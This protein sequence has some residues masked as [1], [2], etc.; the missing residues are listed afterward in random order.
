MIKKRS[1]KAEALFQIILLIVGIMAISYTIGSSVDVVSAFEEE[2]VSKEGTPCIF[3]EKTCEGTV[4]M[5]CP[6][7]KWEIFKNCFSISNPQ[8]CSA[9]NCI[10]SIIY[11]NTGPSNFNVPV[12][13]NLQTD[14]GGQNSG[15]AD[16]SSY[17]QWASQGF[18]AYN[19]Y[20][21]NLKSKPPVNPN[22]AAAKIVEEAAKE[23]TTAEIA[24]AAASAA[25]ALNP[26]GGFILKTAGW[27]AVIYG[28][29]RFLGTRVTDDVN[30]QR[31][32]NVAAAGGS[33]GFT[34]GRIA[35]QILMKKITE[36]V[37]AEMIKS[38]VTAAVAQSTVI[39]TLGPLAGLIALPGF[40]WMMAGA[41][42]I[43]SLMFFKNERYQPVTYQCNAWQPQT[44]GDDCEQCNNQGL[45][46]CTDY[47]CRSLG[48]GCEL[49]NQGT[50]NE[51][52]VWINPND[53]KYPIIEPWENAL[54]NEKYKYSPVNTIN[55]PDRGVDIQYLS[56]DGCIPAFT[57]LSFGVSLD[58]PARCQISPIRVNNFEG[59]GGY[60]LSGGMADYN[61]SFSL[62][63]PGSSSLTSEGIEIENDGN[64]E[65]YVRCEDKNGNSNPANFVFKYC[66][67]PEPDYT[68]PLI[69][70][71]DPLNG[72]PISHNAESLETIFYINEPAECRWSH[73]DQDYENME[74]TMSC[75]ASVMETNAYLLYPC[76][77][78]LTGLENNVENKFY[79]RCK[80]QPS[81]TEQRNTNTESYEY[82][83]IGTEP[84]ILNWVTPNNTLV[85]GPTNSVKVTIESET[86]AGYEDGISTCYYSETGEDGSYIQFYD[87]NSFKHS[88]DL[89]VSEGTYDYY[90]KCIDLG[91][92]ADTAT[93][94]FDVE[95]DT[96]AP[97]I[98]RVYH[99]DG[100]LKIITDEKSECVHS[101]SSNIGCNYNFDEGVSMITTDDLEHYIGWNSN[102]NFYI[103][104][105]DENGLYPNQDQ[106]S[107][108]VRP[109]DIYS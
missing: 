34:A 10:N 99:E 36:Q 65:L 98:A 47:Q 6:S 82:T 69:V 2:T 77:T 25:A 3:G 87:T 80:D 61:H 29:I 51:K 12:N 60:F 107:L 7:N 88:Q 108:I 41:G 95:T 103:K 32:F 38:G 42:I 102:V 27:A 90:V 64:Y 101:T 52:C 63:M 56:S 86:S 8:V 83:L 72:K 93:I 46:P 20:K 1:P 28:G 84:L 54:L 81:S 9:G 43:V 45:L 33:I 15:S 22:E 66:V 57:P 50:G 58:E 92:N 16:Y 89:W 62:V 55:P 104:C 11:P 13:P 105:K 74:N 100:Y 53:V 79:V 30:I 94:N 67:D 73:L 85:K 78:T 109:F 76:T 75:S 71:A 48:Q 21:S 31:G 68:N 14:V 49:I 37:A 96:S 91:G 39:G 106:C 59:M 18:Q 44:G 5:H 35:T 4:A 70:F 26:W 97:I 24:E 19:F 40:G 23:L 17:A